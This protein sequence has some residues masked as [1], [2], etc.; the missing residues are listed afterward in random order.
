MKKS[1]LLL[2]IISILLLIPLTVNARG[3]KTIIGQASVYDQTERYYYDESTLWELWDN[4]HGER[5]FCL[6]HGLHACSYYT[7][8]FENTIYE[9]PAC[10]FTDYGWGDDNGSSQAGTANL[11]WKIR[12]IQNYSNSKFPCQ[13][14]KKISG[15]CSSDNKSAVDDPDAKISLSKVNDAFTIYDN[16]YIMEVKVTKEGSVAK[17]TPSIDT[18]DSNIIVTTSKES[19]E[20]VLNKEIDS[21]SLFVK[22]PRSL[23][24]DNTNVT[25]KVVSKYTTTCNYGIPGLDVYYT[26]ETFCQRISYITWKYDKDEKDNSKEAS[27]SL[28]ANPITGKIKILKIDSNTSLPL[29]NVK[30]VL[31]KSSGEPATYIDGTTVGELTTDSNGEIIIDNLYR[32]TYMLEETSNLS[33]YLKLSESIIIELNSEYVEISVS[34]EPIIIK[35]S[36]QDITN[37]KELSGA[38]MILK[39]EE[40]NT[41]KEFTSTTKPTSF[42][43]SPGVYTLLETIAPNGYEKLETSF[44]FKVNADGSTELIDT[45]SKYFGKNE[46]TIVLYNNIDKVVVPDTFAGLNYILLTL[47]IL[48]IAGGSYFIYKGFKSKKSE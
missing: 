19:N 5:I 16:Y 43:I 34:N 25:L 36:K 22:I 31:H 42:Y 15:F 41:I 30:F 47:G 13:K 28:T 11:H 12:Y 9:G 2:L 46:N 21:N 8:Y 29:A 1:K 33:E 23:V 45:D 44:R 7:Y 18:N 14:Y 40:G 4:T 24:K 39:D 48:A 10:A 32:G 38:S 3:G 37:H 17:Y 35:I 27:I 6:D 26:T 20:N